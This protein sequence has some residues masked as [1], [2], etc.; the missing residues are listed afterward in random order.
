MLTISSGGPLPPLAIT[1]DDPLVAGAT[2]A[3]ALVQRPATTRIEIEARLVDTTTVEVSGGSDEQLVAGVWHI[4]IAAADGRVLVDDV[5]VIVEAVDGWHTIA[6]ARI[7]WRDAPADELHLHELLTVAREQCLAFAPA[8]E[9]TPPASWRLAQLMHA[10]NLWNADRT[11]PGG[12]AGIDGFG[13]T[14]HPLD[15]QIKQLLRPRRP[16]PVAT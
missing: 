15:W 2:V 5:Q 7:A 12:D 16:K 1:L 9:G 4:E 3:A 11:G 10:R 8:R 6:T 14:P 13:L